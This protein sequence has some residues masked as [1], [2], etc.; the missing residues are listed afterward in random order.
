MVTITGDYPQIERRSTGIYSLDFA[1]SSRNGELGMPLRSL[2]EIFGPSGTGK[3]TFSYYLSGCVDP[4][5]KINVAPLELQDKEYMAACVHAAGFSGTLNIMDMTDGKKALT[6][7]KIIDNLSRSV[8]DDGVSAVVL[9]SVGAVLPIVEEEGDL[10]DAFMGKRAKIIGRFSK[11]VARFLI[12]SPNPGV[13]I[14]INHSHQIL[15]GRG[16]VTAGGVTKD[17]MDIVKIG[18]WVKETI[19]S[20]DE[21]A[22]WVI[23]GTVEKLRF[24]KKGRK[25]RV[26]NLPGLGISRNLSAVFDCV[27][28]GLATRSTTVKIGDKSIGYL[29][30]LFEAER[31]GKNEIFQ[32]FHEELDKYKSGVANEP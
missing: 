20:N 19:E 2:Y 27:S 32:P 31:N 13:A 9:D 29:S 11:K 14:L 23:E 1:L 7:E 15:G 6:H 3:S 21:A 30:K 16:H 5:G 22:G 24:G 12:D 17:Y 25:F 28:L 8:L 4:T 10:E 18:L 26:V